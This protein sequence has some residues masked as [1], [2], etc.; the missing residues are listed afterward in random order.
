MDVI[1]AEDR[2]KAL[3]ALIDYHNRRYYQMDDPE[4]PDAEYDRLMREL[5]ELES[6]FPALA[7]KDSPTQRVGS[8]P[9][10]KFEALDHL[11]PM[12]SLANAFSEQDIMDFNERIRR[13]LGATA[14]VRF[15]AEPKLDGVAVNLIYINGILETGLTR[16]DGATGEVITQNIKTI[17]TIPLKMKEKSDAPIPRRIEIR[18]EVFMPT[19]AFKT[20]NGRRLKS[21]EMP[22]ANPRNAAAGSLRQLDS[23]ITTR[24]PLDIFCYGIGMVE[25]TPFQ[26][27]WQVLQA[28]RSWGFRV[29]DH[30]KEVKS[31]A[32]CI[33]YYHHIDNIRKTLPYE[34]DGCVIKVDDLSIQDRLGT[35]SRSP[36]WA[37]ACKFAATRESTV[38]EN[39]IFQIGRTGVLTPVAL[40]KPVR[41]GGVVVSRAT[42]HNMDEIGKKDIRIGDT[43]IIQRAGDVIPE[44]VSVVEAKR[45]GTEK[46]IAKPEICPLAQGGCG[47]KVVRL[48]GEVAYRCINM[49]CPAQIKEHITHFASRGG[50]NIEGL[51]EKLISQLVDRSIVRDPADLYFLSMEKLLTLDR[52]AEK[53]ASNILA[54]IERT[55]SPSLDKF[56]FALGI[57]HVGER[58]SQMLSEHF[59]NLDKIIQAADEEL[60]ALRDIGPEVAGSI[61]RFFDEPSNVAI[62]EKF[63]KAGVVPQEI[64][65]PKSLPLAGKLFVFTGTLKTLGRNEAK[66]I[67]KSLGAQVSEAITKNTDYVVAGDTPGS[68][69]Q[70]ARST[71][72]VILDEE[73]FI[74]LTSN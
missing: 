67:V 19:E 40:M 70:K 8:T 28:L 45:T 6:Q 4:I 48:E 69:L 17:H 32:E 37:I 16:G 29:N 26:S 22:F 20:L 34:I 30:V 42:L 56:I 25:G 15:V 33:R 54:A 62:I 43:V 2:I 31:I 47:S 71:G 13:F 11:T 12:L 63:S 73:E 74:K 38:I 46:K 50:M 39:V 49:G 23:R 57:R 9:L 72:V 18:G 65:R 35:I 36:R 24:R 66:E 44:V 61:S 59:G 7:A 27:H 60:L 58:T 5:M 55:R 52:M 53:S 10:E 51:G 68:K 3:R 1:A 14:D 41:V 64:K 21:G